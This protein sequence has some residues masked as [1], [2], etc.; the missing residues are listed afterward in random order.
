MYVLMHQLFLFY[1]FISCFS[2]NADFF[3]W[4]DVCSK[5]QSHCILPGLYAMIGAAATLGGVTRM[6]GVNQ[7]L[8]CLLFVSTVCMISD[9]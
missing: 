8:F 9:I 5:T 2:S 4:K 6:T 7:L 1:Y 3:L